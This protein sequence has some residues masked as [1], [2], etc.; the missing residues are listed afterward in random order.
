MKN[1]L[2]CDRVQWKRPEELRKRKPTCVRAFE[3]DAHW[4]NFISN[5]FDWK[6]FMP[7]M[8]STGNS[9]TNFHQQDCEMNLVHCGQRSKCTMLHSQ[10][11]KGWTAKFSRSPYLLSVTWFSRKH[12]ASGLLH[13]F[14]NVLFTRHFNFCKNIFVRTL[15]TVIADSKISLYCSVHMG[16]FLC[17]LGILSTY[18]LWLGEIKEALLPGKFN[19]THHLQ[20]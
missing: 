8:L 13:F 19:S 4:I 18:C 20:W 15:K 5:S 16:K 14:V 7:L 17:Q 12:F 9:M 1:D 2:Q 10:F 6:F 11:H 3:L